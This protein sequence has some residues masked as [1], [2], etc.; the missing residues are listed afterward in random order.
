MPTH[1]HRPNRSLG[2]KIFFDRTDGGITQPEHN[3]HRAHMARPCDYT[4]ASHPT[5]R[6]R[7]SAS[8]PRKAATPTTASQTPPLPPATVRPPVI[9]HLSGPGYTPLGM[10]AAGYGVSA[11]LRRGRTAVRSR[12]A[13]CGRSWVWRSWV[14][15]CRR[16]AGGYQRR[17]GLSVQ[18][19]NVVC[20]LD[21]GGVV[22]G[23]D[24]GLAFLV[25]NCGEESRDGLGVV[26]VLPRGRLVGDQQP[27]G[28]R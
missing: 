10:N 6:R 11:L 23:A 3:G 20:P 21:H 25:G 16:M 12:G 5:S 1:D 18:A 24:N 15:R 9:V 27:P 22:G 2:I 17:P 19:D 28:T 7:C 13:E 14:W 26:L 8:R 4:R